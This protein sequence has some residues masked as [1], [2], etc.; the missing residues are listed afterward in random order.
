MKHKAAREARLTESGVLHVLHRLSRTV[1]GE[2]VSAALFG[3][4]LTEARQRIDRLI[5]QTWVDISILEHVEQV[6]P[7]PAQSVPQPFDML[8]ETEIM[9]SAFLGGQ[10]LAGRLGNRDIGSRGPTPEGAS[11]VYRQTDHFGSGT[12]W[13]GHAVIASTCTLK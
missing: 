2:V 12:A 6:I 3:P 5:D 4:L 10:E 13:S 8:E 11:D 1:R 9:P 7:A